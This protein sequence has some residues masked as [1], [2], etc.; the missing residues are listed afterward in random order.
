MTQSLART[1]ISPVHTFLGKL[2]RPFPVYSVQL[3][4]LNP[5][6]K[7]RDSK[8]RDR[9]WRGEPNLPPGHEKLSDYL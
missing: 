2:L 9:R 3:S 7:R 6:E 1:A 8:R 5:S 4:A